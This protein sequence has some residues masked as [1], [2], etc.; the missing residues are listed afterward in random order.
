[1]FQRPLYPPTT[2]RPNLL[3]RVSFQEP[4]FDKSSSIDKATIVTACEKNVDVSVTEM[5]SRDQE[6]KPDDAKEAKE[7]ETPTTKTLDEKPED[8]QLSKG[9]GTEDEKSC[10][11]SE[12][13]D[14]TKDADK[15]KL[16]NHGEDQH[17]GADKEE[18]AKD[19]DDQSIADSHAVFSDSEAKG[20]K[21][22]GNKNKRQN[23]RNNNNKSNKAGNKKCW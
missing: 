19:G 11:R 4:C 1:M 14:T 18:T 7:Y 13:D 16:A 15:E 20:V 3:D 5:A 22:A 6:T 17:K 10:K 12:E 21:G 2:P 23:Q 9:T 8:S